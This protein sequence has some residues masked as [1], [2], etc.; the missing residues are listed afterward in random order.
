[1]RHIVFALFVWTDHLPPVEAVSAWLN[2]PM[3]KNSRVEH[4]GPIEFL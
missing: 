2:S 1:M 3:I 4:L